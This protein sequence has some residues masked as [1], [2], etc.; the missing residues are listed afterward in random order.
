M[1]YY[2]ED[3]LDHIENLPYEIQ[4]NFSYMNQKD[5]QFE[6]LRT[7]V[8]D[9]H[10]VYLKSTKRGPGAASS[11]NEHADILIAQANEEYQRAVEIIDDKIAIANQTVD[12]LEQHIKRLDSK[13]K[14]FEKELEN[15]GALSAITLATSQSSGDAID[16]DASFDM[17]FSGMPSSMVKTLSNPSLKKKGLSEL[18]MMDQ[19]TSPT[20]STGR[21]SRR[22]KSFAFSLID[23][24]E[25]SEGFTT[26]DEQPEMA[27]TE[28]MGNS[29]IYGTGIPA[30]TDTIK[31]AEEKDETEEEP[32]YCVCRQVSYGDM[33]AC[34]NPNVS[35][36]MK[37]GS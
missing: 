10:H 33:V 36:Q 12:I 31:M 2:L 13:I 7:S 14:I 32:L 25:M 6:D 21:K 11:K 26:E 23:V 15:Q 28:Y 1:S 19:M 5:Q 22:P 16:E 18:D 17:L 35:T 20:L 29:D 3:Y 9:R 8:V 24:D 34:D 37:G 30:S 4:Q 27:D